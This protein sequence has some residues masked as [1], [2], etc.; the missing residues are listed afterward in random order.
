[1]DI[2]QELTMLYE[3]QRS[4]S[5]AKA[6]PFILLTHRFRFRIFMSI[7]YQNLAMPNIGTWYVL[8]D[9]SPSQS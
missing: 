5:E 1:V 6:A 3:I 9:K 7:M 2:A 8:A 4:E